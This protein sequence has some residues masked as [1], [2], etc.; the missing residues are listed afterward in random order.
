MKPKKNKLELEY[1]KQTQ[2]I[3]WIRGRCV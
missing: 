1:R 3:R 2:I